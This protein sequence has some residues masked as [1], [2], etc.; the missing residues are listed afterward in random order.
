M[1]QCWSG[2]VST[3]VAPSHMVQSATNADAPDDPN[4]C[5]ADPA[6]QAAAI[7]KFLGGALDE[8][9]MARGVDPS[10]YRNKA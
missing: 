10:L 8:Q 4:A 5:V 2:N 1:I 6:K 9:A 3:A 7:N